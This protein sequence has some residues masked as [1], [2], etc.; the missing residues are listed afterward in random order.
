MGFWPPRGAAAA[1]AAAAA[2]RVRVRVRVRVLQVGVQEGCHEKGGAG[3][4]WGT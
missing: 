1:A 2:A 4:R 3:I